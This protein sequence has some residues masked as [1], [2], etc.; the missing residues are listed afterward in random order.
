MR[1]EVRTE[2][3]RAKTELGIRHLTHVAQGANNW[4]YTGRGRAGQ[5]YAVKVR[6]EGRGRFATAAWAASRLAT[7]GVPVPVIAWHGVFVC[8]EKY[9][10]GQPLDRLDAEPDLAEV[11]DAVRRIH[12]I[13]VGGY[14]RLDP[15]GVGE[16]SC[17][18]SWLLKPFPQPA[19]AP[20]P[21]AQLMTQ[22][23]SQLVE[24]APLLDAVR[25]QLLHG[26]LR[27]RHFYLD[28]TTVT[29]VID[30]ESARGGDPLTDL[31]GWSLQEPAV[32]TDP[33]LSNYFAAEPISPAALTRLTC[34]RLRIAP[35]LAAW[36][37]EQDNNDLAELQLR[38]IDTDLRNLSAGTPT[39]LPD[40]CL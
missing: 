10:T 16:F 11:A 38:Q 32:L 19:G 20:A 30:W 37:L 13:P 40:P 29:G 36:H 8:V 18:H 26:D 25:P 24:H 31:G 15:T 21:W 33:L 4:V 17:I 3:E 27:A 14:G 12:Q 22:I 5:R 7:H 9:C 35:W 39:V 23:R 28:A 34:Y 6:P 1:D 2:L